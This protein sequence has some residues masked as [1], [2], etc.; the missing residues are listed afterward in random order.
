[1][2]R[3]AFVVL[4]CALLLCQQAYAVPSFLRGGAKIR[5][6]AKPQALRDEA[7]ATHAK[8]LQA[9]ETFAEGTPAG[10]AIVARQALFDYATGVAFMF[11]SQKVQGTKVPDVTKIFSIPIVGSFELD[12]TDI[13]VNN[14][15]CSTSSANL[16]I[17][18]DGFFHLLASDISANLTFK[19]HWTKAS[20]SGTGDGELLLGGGTIDWVFELHKDEALQKPQLQVVTAN[21]AFDSVDLK[22]HSYSADWLYQAVL[23]LFNEAV[24][25]QVQNGV[26]AALDGEVP[27]RINAVLGSLPTKLEVRGLP[28]STSFEY[29]IYTSAFVLV[30]GFGEVEVPDQLQAAAAAAALPQPQRRRLTSST[31]TGT[32]TSS[33]SSSSDDGAGDEAEAVAQMTRCPFES[34]PLPLD[35]AALASDPAMTSVYVHEATANCLLWGLHRAGKLAFALKDGTVPGLSITTDVLAMLVPELPTLYPHMGMIINVEALDTPHVSLSAAAGA[36]VSA[37]YRMSL[38]VANES[39]GNPEVV[40]LAANLTVSAQPDWDAFTI[41]DVAAHHVVEASQLSVP[42]EQ[43]DNTVTWLIQNYGPLA[44]LKQVFELLV[45]TPDSSQVELTSARTATYDA[46]FA[47]SADVA[48]TLPPPPA[49]AVAA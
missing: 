5:E 13:V 1:M 27:A 9:L 19:W 38:V 2:A 25:R 24:K 30:K 29:S 40:R 18:G 42:A 49:P 20:L 28:F 32:D 15:S 21:S 17:L 46:W 39:L 3:R 6:Q 44:S 26:S 36:T 22:I 8:S 37:Y 10:I 12:L 4:A 48:V 16:T 31:R 23:T 35:G 33:D 43:W 47:L 34:S 11:L 45:H 14:F 7:E 41:G